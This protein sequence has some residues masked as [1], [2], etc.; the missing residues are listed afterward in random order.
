[1]S[2]KNVTLA[3][4][5]CLA[6]T[7]AASATILNNLSL[8]TQIDPPQRRNVNLVA[9]NATA[10][11]TVEASLGDGGV[12]ND[13]RQSADPAG[14]QNHTI[15][16]TDA[17]LPDIRLQRIQNH[18]GNSMDDSSKAQATSE[19]EALKLINEN[20]DDLITD[21]IFGDYTSGTFT[22]FTSQ[23]VEAVGF[24]MGQVENDT[25]FTVEFFA[26]NGAL[27]ITQ[28]AV[29]TSNSGNASTVFFGYVNSTDLIGRVRITRGN[30]GYEET[31]LGDIAFSGVIPEPASMALLA[32]GGSLMLA[33]R[34]VR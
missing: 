6:V 13:I 17:T 24:T 11:T 26:P 27:L 4:A 23:G 1:M 29:G 25:P 33:R 16:F 7:S 2:M 31:Y 30:S 34:R 12:I 20:N 14:G 3:V 22:A 28:T 18:R 19:G 8:G 9:T 15:T 32:I 5:F 10:E 21:I